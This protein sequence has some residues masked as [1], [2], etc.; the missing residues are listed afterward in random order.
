MRIYSLELTV[1]TPLIITGAKYGRVIEHSIN[2]IPGSSIRGSILTLLKFMNSKLV[3]EE[4]STPKMI[5]H[6]AYPISQDGN[7]SYPSDPLT[8][9]CKICGEIVQLPVKSPEDL[10]IPTKY[11]ENH[12]CMFKNIG[13]SLIYCRNGKLKSL[14]LKHAFIEAVGINKMLR[15]SETG[16]LY[17]YV[18]LAP[19]VVF[20]GLV[21]D[22]IDRLE[23]MIK[24]VGLSM[25]SLKLK[26]GRRVSAGL[27][28]V[29]AK[30]AEDKN[31]IDRRIKQLSSTNGTLCLLAKSPVFNLDYDE[32]DIF[33]TVKSIGSLPVKYVFKTG[34]VEVSGYSIKS[35]TP[36]VMI[37]GLNIGSLIV[38]DARNIC[39]EDLVK[40]ELHG[41]GPFST[42]GLNIVEVVKR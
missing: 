40:L 2:Y 6:P 13:G 26:I 28:R 22:P 18:A 24:D 31:Y 10:R 3:D 37:K 20:R 30:I 4:I 12:I 5:F 25:N 7:Q 8:F 16:L 17:S 15:S 39:V 41:V 29:E 33:P 19:G 32:K 21:I 42:A 14:N 36:K 34:I 9:K 35:N 23:Q 38:P 27:G 11:G 1:N